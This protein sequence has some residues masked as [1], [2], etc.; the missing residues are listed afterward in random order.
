MRSPAVI[1]RPAIATLLV[2]GCGDGDRRTSGG[3]SSSC[4][5][6]PGCA[7]ESVLSY[8]SSEPEPDVTSGGGNCT[9]AS[10]FKDTAVATPF[11][12]SVGIYSSPPE[13]L[14]SMG[15]HTV[16]AGFLRAEQAAPPAPVVLATD[17]PCSL[18]DWSSYTDAS[19]GGGAFLGAGQLSLDVATKTVMTERGDSGAY[20]GGG[21]GPLIEGCET[22]RVRAT[23]EPGG[24]PTFE[25]SVSAPSRIT[26][27]TPKYVDTALEES[28]STPLTIAW[29]G[30]TNGTVAVGLSSIEPT[31][32]PRMVWCTISATAREL[33]IV[34]SLLSQVSAGRA[35]LLVSTGSG[36]TLVKGDWTFRASVRADAYGGSFSLNLQ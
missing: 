25:L 10:A 12:G 23:G 16:V 31:A 24:A 30:G 27:T 35:V 11:V 32:A 1:V 14:A 18:Q 7:G 21:P 29:T 8:A 19:P 6:S 28:R 36:Q 26:V 22:M 15:Q 4:D 33:T 20:G 2:I 9:G 17:G 3:A 13:I 34:S 5:G